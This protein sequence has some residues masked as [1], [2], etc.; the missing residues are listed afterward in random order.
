MKAREGHTTPSGPQ[1]G[2]RDGGSGVM[3]RVLRTGPVLGPERQAEGG[4]QTTMG[5]PRATSCGSHTPTL[6]TFGLVGA[7][8]ALGTCVFTGVTARRQC[9]PGQA[10]PVARCSPHCPFEIKGPRGQQARWQHLSFFQP[11][12]RRSQTSGAPVG[13]GRVDLLAVGPL[14]QQASGDKSRLQEGFPCK[15]S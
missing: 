6:H 10:F 1:G 4:G 3:C 8:S 15:A 12:A 9:R 2:R 14:A 5:T 7:P 11:P 13:G